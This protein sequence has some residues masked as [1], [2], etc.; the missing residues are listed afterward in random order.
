MASFVV[1][2]YSIYS[3]FNSRLSPCFTTTYPSA[4]KKFQF[5]KSRLHQ[6]RCPFRHDEGCTRILHFDFRILA[7]ET[8]FRLLQKKQ[9]D[10]YQFFCLL[11]ITMASVKSKKRI[12]CKYFDNVQLI[13]HV[14]NLS[15]NRLFTI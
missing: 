1:P 9:L 3:L 8:T 2:L 13:F 7:S 4:S 5:H 14:S 15:K 12:K 6:T 11:S 10:V